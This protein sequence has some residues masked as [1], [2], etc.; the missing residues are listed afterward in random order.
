MRRKIISRK[1]HEKRQQQSQL[2]MGVVLI[3]LMLLSVIGYS[4]MGQP[5]SEEDKDFIEYHG[6]NFANQ[7]GLWIAENGALTIA[8]SN[9]PNEISQDVFSNFSHSIN[10]FNG[11]PLYIS[12]P[13]YLSKREIAI[14]LGNPETNDI[15]QRLQ[16]AC[17]GD[18]NCTGDFPL[19]TC[20]DNIIIVRENN[21][22]SISQEDNCI[23]I[24]APKENLTKVTDLFLLKL[25]NI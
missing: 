19:K 5:D 3:V 24:S 4:F 23:F 17:Y 11:M 1:N 21:E 13:N 22:S 7:N 2:I 12:S 9:N 16:D 20:D 6:V 10:N 14:N 15:V 18:E 25:F 8:L